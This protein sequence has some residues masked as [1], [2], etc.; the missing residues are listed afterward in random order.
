MTR[1]SARRRGPHL[2]ALLTACATGAAL[3]ATPATPTP[4]VSY[5]G[6]ALHF[7]FPALEVGVAEYEEGPTGVTVLNFPRLVLA[8]IDVRGGAPGTIN[9]DV[10]HMPHDDARVNSIVLT[11]GSAYGL[12]AAGG[13]SNGLKERLADPGDFR[14]VAVVAGAVI[15]DMGGRRFNAITPDEILGKAALKAARPGWVPLGARGAGRFAMQGGYFDPQHSGQG[16]AFRQSGPTKVLVVTIV[17]S[18]GSIVGR[19]GKLLRCTH[20]AAGGDCGTINERIDAHLRESAAPNSAALAVPVPNGPTANTTITCVITNEKM[21]FSMLQRLAIQVHNSMSRAIQPFGT[22]ADGDTLFAV[23]TGEVSNPA[24]N[25]VELGILASETAWD[26][27][28]ASPPPAPSTTPASGAAPAPQAQAAVAGRYQFV[29]GVIAVVRLA[30]GALQVEISGRDSLYLAQGMPAALGFI[31]GDE[32]EL[33]TPRADR[34]RFERDRHGRVVAL[35]LAP[36]PWPLHAERL[37]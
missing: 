27:V 33:K 29:P 37:P 8:A 22:L 5:D 7:D 31:A 20:P 2:L 10:V 3:A 23:T 36:G 30:S 28:L 4:H 15:F 18:L 6:P 24:L 11:G 34:V 16:A 9:S 14:Q 25:P 13:V 26:A 21:P 12:T 32:Y 19:D 17:N 1:P 35:T